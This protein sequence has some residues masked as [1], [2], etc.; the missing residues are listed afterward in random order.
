MIAALPCNV[1]RAYL[2]GDDGTSEIEEEGRIE[3]ALHTGT[4]ATAN[5]KAKPAHVE[6]IVWHE[7]GRTKL[8][9]S[10]LAAAELVNRLAPIVNALL[11]PRAEVAE[12]AS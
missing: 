1:T 5:K 4:A 10:V 8:R 6:M 9:L 2:S 7:C 11:P 3:L 12:G